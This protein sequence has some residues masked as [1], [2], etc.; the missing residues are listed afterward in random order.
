[1][2]EQENFNQIPAYQQVIS[3]EFSKWQLWGEDLLDQLA[4]GLRGETFD[5]EKGDQGKW[6]KAKN[7]QP[8]MNEDGIQMVVNAV[9]EMAFNKFMFLSE[10][11]KDEIYKEL[12]DGINDITSTIADRHKFFGIRKGGYS[13]ATLI[14]TKVFYMVKSALLM[15]HKAGM[16]DYLGKQVT[17][18][19]QYGRAGGEEKK[20][21]GFFGLFKNKEE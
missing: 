4:H 12:C 1:M 11:E 6:I 5:R 17:E 13:D 15:S 10:K 9:R 21:R 2:E 16:R 18:I 7:I 3:D 14:I 8:I 19:R 20:K